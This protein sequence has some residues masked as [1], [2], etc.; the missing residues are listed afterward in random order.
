MS[1]GGSKDERALAG[2]DSRTGDPSALFWL[3]D[4]QWAAVEPHL[5]RNQ[6]GPIRVDDRQVLSG[7]IHVFKVGCRWRDCPI[8]YG[9]STTIYNR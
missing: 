7:I 1:M 6:P 3:S 9:P 2:Q 8:E 5:P 4:R